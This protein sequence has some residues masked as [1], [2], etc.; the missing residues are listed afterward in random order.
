MKI[1]EASIFLFFVV[2]SEGTG[3][4]GSVFTAQGVA[5]WYPALAKPFF[6]PPSWIFAPV[7]TLLYFLMGWAAYL[8]WRQRNKNELARPALILFFIHLVFNFLWS[9]IFFGWQQIGWAL[10]EI[11]LLDILIITLMLIF[12]KV[13]KKASYLLIPYLAWVAFASVLNLSLLLL[14]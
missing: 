14:N 6:N 1:K 7:W 10:A 12:Y 13:D 3:I 9:V 5:S 8:V 2:I 11:I 4:L